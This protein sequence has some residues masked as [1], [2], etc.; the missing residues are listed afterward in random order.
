MNAVMKPSSRK[1]N[2][3]ILLY[4]ANVF[5]P[6]AL[7][8][9]R[10]RETEPTACPHRPGAVDIPQGVLLLLGCAGLQPAACLS[11]HSSEPQNK[12]K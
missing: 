2:A 7:A 8:S 5:G 3:G 4:Q 11:P 10:G 6:P 1:R 12:P 9:R